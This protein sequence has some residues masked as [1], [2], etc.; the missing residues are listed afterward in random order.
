ML[1]K[2]DINYVTILGQ[3]LWHATIKNKKMW[4]GHIRGAM[5]V[6]P[7]EDYQNIISER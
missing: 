7:E 3:K 4:T 5:R 2:A 1:W 6:I